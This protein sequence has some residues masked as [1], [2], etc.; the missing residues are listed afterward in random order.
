MLIKL[1]ER[2]PVFN[3]VSTLLMIW[4]FYMVAIS[5]TNFVSIPLVFSFSDY[6]NIECPYF[7]AEIQLICLCLDMLLSLNTQ[8]FENGDVITSRAKIARHYILKKRRLLADVV[9]LVGF[10]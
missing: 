8:Y 7:Y 5:V 3:P 4:N 10:L 9:S 2:I 1:M 6:I